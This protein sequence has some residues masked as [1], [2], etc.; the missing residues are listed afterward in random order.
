VE[1][2]NDVAENINCG[3]FVPSE[4]GHGVVHAMVTTTVEEDEGPS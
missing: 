2:E 3:S 4:D 1:A